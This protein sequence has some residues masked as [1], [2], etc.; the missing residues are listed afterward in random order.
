MHADRAARSAACTC[1]AKTRRCR[2]RTPT[3]RES[4]AALE[5]AS[6]GHLPH[7]DRRARGRDPAGERV[8]REDRQFTN[9]DRT[10]QIGAMRSPRRRRAA[11]PVDHR[12][13]NRQSAWLQLEL[14]ARRRCSTRCAH[15]AEHRRITWERLEREGAVTYPCEH[16]GDAGQP[17][18]FVDRFPPR[19]AAR[20]VPADIVPAAERPDADYPMVL[21]TGA[22]SS[23]GTPAA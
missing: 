3:T 23:T 16:E 17:V 22:N 5:H 21:I 19:A 1:R 7:R 14:R 4:L 20:F 18:V 2:T 9:T 13:Q 10:L 15:H 11:G 8:P 6:S 12:R